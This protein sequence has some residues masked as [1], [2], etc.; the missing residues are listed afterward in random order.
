[1]RAPILLLLA[2]LAAC[3]GGASAYATTVGVLHPGQTMTV[4]I[5]AG[6]VNAYAPA[7][8]DPRDRF[9]LSAF[10]DAPGA[11]AP[12]PQIKTV[13]GGIDVEA[14]AMRSL[15]VRVPEGVDLT[16]V[17]RGGDVNVTDITGN[18]RVLAM[19]GAT[20][21]MLPGYAQASIA[22]KGTLSVTMG[23]TSWRGTLHFF[24]ARGDIDIWIVENARFHAHLH[25]DNGTIFTDFTL[26]GSS[27]GASETIDAAVNGSASRGIDVESRKGSIRLLRLV[28]Q[29]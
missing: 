12:A 2:F 15:L 27:R 21:L 13:R 9:T 24:N 10:A 14:P 4:R 20:T 23:S 11:Y 7:A 3:D 17:S 8:G 18:A 19:S 16:V 28:P 6:I 5:A 22:R 26:R 29:V 1:M 25:T